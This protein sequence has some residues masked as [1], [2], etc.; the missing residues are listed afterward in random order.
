[1]LLSGVIGVCGVRIDC[2]ELLG[3]LVWVGSYILT[4]AL[5][6][7]NDAA[8][9]V[10]PAGGPID[11][12]PAVANGNLMGISISSSLSWTS[13]VCSDSIVS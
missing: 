5:V 7:N 8:C 9:C 3:E 4:E 2:S 6:L 13:S 11:A 12:V 10:A 1:M